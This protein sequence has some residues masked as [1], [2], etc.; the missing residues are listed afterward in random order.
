MWR[1]SRAAIWVHILH[2]AYSIGCFGAVHLATPFIQYLFQV[3]GRLLLPGPSYQQMRPP[4]LVDQLA[5][6]HAHADNKT[7]NAGDMT[8]KLF[9]SDISPNSSTSVASADRIRVSFHVLQVPYA[10]VCLLLSLFFLCSSIFQTMQSFRRRNSIRRKRLLKQRNRNRQLKRDMPEPE[11]RNENLYE[12]TLSDKQKGTQTDGSKVSNTTGNRQPEASVNVVESTKSEYS[13]A[14]N[15][16]FNSAFTHAPGHEFRTAESKRGGGNASSRRCMDLQPNN[17]KGTPKRT[18]GKSGVTMEHVPWFQGSQ[19]FDIPIL[20]FLY[21]CFVFPFGLEA[22]LGMFLS[23]YASSNNALQQQQ[24]QQQQLESADDAALDIDVTVQLLSVFWASFILGRVL[25]A[26]LSRFLSAGAL[27]IAFLTINVLSSA[28]LAAYADKY[29]TILFLFVA[30]F[31]GF[32][33]PFIPGG[34]TWANVFL[35]A[36]PKSIALAY[37]SAGLGWAICCWLSGFLISYFS[38]ST[39][40][41]LVAGVSSLSVILFI[42]VLMK[43]GAP[44]TRRKG[45][46]SVRKPLSTYV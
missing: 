31:G 42:P 21:V 19:T 15:G 10:I 33:G 9:S 13:Q 44:G 23:A 2:T 3:E 25:T 38:K 26:S 27:L 45:N 39:L 29:P 11:Q 30:I 14:K 7:A 41:F 8:N 35:V 6:A 46:R 20:M 28:I 18:R 43:V 16:F 32:L 1:E 22:T 40:M 4:P 12:D 36:T 34:F 24:Q 17:Y 5:H 37:C